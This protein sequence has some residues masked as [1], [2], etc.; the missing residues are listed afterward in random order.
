MRQTQPPDI[1]DAQELLKKYAGEMQETRQI[2]LVINNTRES[3]YATLFQC[4]MTG[5]YWH[6]PAQYEVTIGKQGFALPGAK[7]E[8]DQKSPQGLFA[9]GTAFGYESTYPTGLVYQQV[10]REDLW[11]DDASHPDYN[12]WVKAPS[13]ANSWEIMRRED[14]QYRIGAVIAYN[15]YPVIAGKGSAVF[16]H[17]QEAPGT[18]TTACIAMKAGEIGTIMQWLHKKNNPKVLMGNLEDLML[19]R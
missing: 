7:Q 16:L 3:H 11:I 15:T 13:D 1:A 18:G 9:L 2:L 19:M 6:I 14:H 4:E 10:S 17:I 12:K 5:T 8:G